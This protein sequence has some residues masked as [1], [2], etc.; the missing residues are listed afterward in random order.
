[1]CYGE[2]GVQKQGEDAKENVGQSLN[3]LDPS[4]RSGRHPIINR[5]YH[6]KEPSNKSLLLSLPIKLAK[7]SPDTTQ[8]LGKGILAYCGLSMTFPPLESNLEITNE[9]R[10]T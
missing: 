6:W 8:L 7:F 2:R 5:L 10:N 9:I 4:W 3:N 1:M